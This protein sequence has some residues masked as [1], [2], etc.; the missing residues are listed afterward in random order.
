MTCSVIFVLFFHGY[1]QLLPWHVNVIDSGILH[2]A[3]QSCSHDQE[4]LLVTADV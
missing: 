2:G 4:P 1:E 3:S